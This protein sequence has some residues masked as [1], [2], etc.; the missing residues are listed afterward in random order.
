[1]NEGNKRQ[2]HNRIPNP[3]RGDNE[4]AWHSEAPFW[5]DLSDREVRYQE[6]RDI[7]CRNTGI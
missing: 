4:D 2:G 5:D 3:M 6:S 7:Q 1:M